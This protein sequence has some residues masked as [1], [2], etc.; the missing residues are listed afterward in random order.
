[1]LQFQTMTVSS[2]K[3]LYWTSLNFVLQKKKHILL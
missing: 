3:K 1:M 2:E